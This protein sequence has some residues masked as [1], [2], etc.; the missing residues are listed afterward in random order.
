[1]AGFLD[2][3][4]DLITAFFIRDP[5]ELQKRRRLRDMYDE[6]RQVRPL[7]YRRSSQQL[8]PEF[9]AEVLRLAFLLRPL[10]EV[11]EKTT[12]NPD[13]KL[14]QRYKD[15]LVL[16]RLPAE[17]Q[18]LYTSLLQTALK[19]RVLEASDPVEELAGADKELEE[20]MKALDG[21][22]LYGF[23]RSYTAT[24]RLVALS[25]HDFLPLLRLFDPALRSLDTADPAEFR[26]VRGEEALQALLDFYFILAG[27]ELSEGVEN[28]LSFLL[29]RLTGD[30]SEAAKDRMK[31]VLNR[32]KDLV[33]EKFRSETILA[34][35]RL[36]QKEPH[37]VPQ[38]IQEEST[39]LE[40]FKNRL[41]IGYQRSKDRIEVVLRERSV[42][43]DLRRLFPN[44]LLL[45]IEGYREDIDQTLQEREFDGFSNIRPLRIL[46]SYSRGHFERELKDNLKRLIVEGKFENK[47][48][49][50]MFTNTFFQCEAMMGK[51]Q[52]FEEWLHGSGPQSVTKLPK[53]IELLDKGKPVHS[54]VASVLETIDEESRKLVNEGANCFYN[55]CVILLEILNDAKQKTP[56]QIQNI[57]FLSG[58][59]TQEYLNLLSRG[60]DNLYLFTKIMKNF[61]TIK[62]LTM[63]TGGVGA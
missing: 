51:I 3:L 12:C 26:A 45:E 28:N 59:K 17:L 63:D 20:L 22:E 6:L 25:Q 18:D 38:T 46:K 10:R 29:E 61:T 14:A 39:F 56:A 4:Q 41:Q 37:F 13:P 31:K 57:K 54:M 60:Y 34:L 58:K 32:L 48:F 49:Q 55:L 5:Y 52:Q 27:L 30:R 62:Q 9:A 40:A 16:A 44:A 2:Y 19:D 24:D 8:Q 1:M 15:Y 43:E 35:L 50:N 11:F 23:E 53:Y 42:A 7:Y 21:S 36:I 33:S 47:I